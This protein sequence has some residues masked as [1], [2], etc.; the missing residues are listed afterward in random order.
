VRLVRVSE[1]VA[2]NPHQ[3]V[4]VR[5]HP[6]QDNGAQVILTG[7]N[8]LNLVDIRPDEIMVRIDSALVDHG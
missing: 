6:G 1:F 5:D 2:F 4:M 8:T 7:N 3:V